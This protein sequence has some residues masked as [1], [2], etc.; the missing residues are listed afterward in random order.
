[1]KR[2]QGFTLVELLVV[3]AIIAILASIVVPNVSR[4]IERSRVAKALSEINGIELALT[5]MVAD[6]ERSN[7]NQLL[8]P[9]A[10]L[11][12]AEP[13]FYIE[14]VNLA[15]GDMRFSVEGMRKARELY[16][17]FFY[18]LLTQG[19][20]VLS[21]ENAG[22]FNDQVVQRLGL[23]YMD[24]GPDP[25]GS[26]Y[27]IFPGPWTGPR[28]A[29]PPP[30]RKFTVDTSGSSRAIRPPDV[31][32]V[33]V[34][35]NNDMVTALQDQLAEYPAEVSYPADR[36]KLA[37]IWSY[38]AN[39]RN[40]QVVYRPSFGGLPGQSLKETAM[41]DQLSIYD[42]YSDEVDEEYFFGGD[43]INN[44]D[45]GRTWARFYS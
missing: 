34:A 35:S 6:A 42:I 18:G 2:E 30:F 36:N 27:R 15:R 3:M 19:R 13:R 5:A 11:D 28:S 12:P 40:S 17:T 25:W 38:G 37:F 43:D 26:D 24:I 21:G 44:W 39:V 9:D 41:Y 10:L 1:M 29:S 16:T 7:I 22:A 14:R 23:S 20:Q 4:Y 31:L 32:R 45:K 8:N 33:T